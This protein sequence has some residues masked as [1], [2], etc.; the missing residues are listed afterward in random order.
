MSQSKEFTVLT[1]GLAFPE[2]PIWLECGDLLVVEIAAQQLTRI[3]PNGKTHV[4]AELQGGPNGAALGPD[5]K[6]Y[7]CNNGGF[8]WT[9]SGGV[10][11]SVAPT[12]RNMS[13]STLR[14]S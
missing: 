3:E 8:S 11:P 4:V 14:L 2:G 9:K 10:L 7:I 13:S 5:G 6:V 1:D 12:S